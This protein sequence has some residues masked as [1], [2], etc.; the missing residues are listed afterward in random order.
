MG[1]PSGIVGLQPRPHAVCYGDRDD[2]F[3]VYAIDA[4]DALNQV[5][6]YAKTVLNLSNREIEAMCLE[7]SGNTL[8]D[9]KREMLP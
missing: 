2:L 6:L 8:E 1:S 3:V 9:I 5:E 7:C 4:E